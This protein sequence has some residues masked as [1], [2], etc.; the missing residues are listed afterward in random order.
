MRRRD[1]GH[2]EGR[3][4]AHQHH[5]H[6]REVDGFERAGARVVALLALDFEA[7]GM[8][9]QRA[10]LEAQGLG[11]VVAQRM[12]ARLGF[13]SQREGRIGVDIDILDRVHLDCDLEAHR[14]VFSRFGECSLR[15]AAPEI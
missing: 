4:L 3:I 10:V 7:A 13:E 9:G 1:V 5:V 11:Q 6:R 8:G 15:H 2:V 14:G 12:S